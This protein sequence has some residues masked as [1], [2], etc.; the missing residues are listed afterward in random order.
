M[1]RSGIETAGEVESIEAEHAIV[2]SDLAAHYR[3]RALRSL[4]AGQLTES[5]ALLREALKV[6]PDDVDIL[7]ELGVAIWRQGRPAEAELIHRRARQIK[8]D[9]FRVLTNLGLAVYQSGR[10]DEAGDLYR[11]ALEVRPDCFDAMM[12]LGVVSSDLGRF[13]EAARWLDAALRLRPDSADALHDVGM[14]LARQ[15]RW[16][17]AIEY[18][19]AALR[20]QPEMVEAHLNLAYLLLGCGEYDRGWVEY[21]WRLKLR[22]PPGCRINRTFWNGDNLQG[23]TILLHFEQGLG[24]TLQFIRYA[25]L[26]KRKGGRVVV[27]CQAPVVKLVARCAGV[28]LACDGSGF[29]PPCDVHAPLASL[30]GIFG[31]TLETVPARVPYLVPDAILAD[32]WGR[33][34]ARQVGPGPAGGAQPFRIGIAWQG[35]PAQKGDRW[36]SI[37]LVR[38][39]PLAAVPGVSLISLQTTHGVDQLNSADRSFAILELANRRGR[40]FDE[41]AAIASHLDLVICPDTALAHLAGGLGVPVWIGLSA[42]GDWRYP[43][44][45]SQTPWYPTMRIFRQTTL[46]DWDGVVR[47]MADA[48][49]TMMVQ[50]G[51]P[52]AD[53]GSARFSKASIAPF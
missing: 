5:E 24:D 32:H 4:L 52:M 9:D 15:C 22:P 1:K 33:E 13:D 28:D 21:E 2:D 30:A 44:G 26:V 12:N 35:N 25:E 38:F 45:R 51:R 11:Q 7:S 8:P 29:E 36:R 49:R 47:A 16:D 39:A 3:E 50:S 43:H 34:L 23:R 40:D 17:D 37:P 27:L 46:G 48:L 42:V 14:N 19:E 31:T 18:Y 20:R 53:G 10:I 41:T 6:R